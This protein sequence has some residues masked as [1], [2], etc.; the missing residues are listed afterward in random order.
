V[1]T[2]RRSKAP[3]ALALSGERGPRQWEHRAI[4]WPKPDHHMFM[5]GQRVLDA[6]V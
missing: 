5:A 2:L 4:T 1:K 3:R 6:L